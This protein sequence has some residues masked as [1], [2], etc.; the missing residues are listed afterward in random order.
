VAT[1]AGGGDEAIT[2][3]K[4]SAQDIQKATAQILEMLA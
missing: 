1:W 4:A 3:L 2:A